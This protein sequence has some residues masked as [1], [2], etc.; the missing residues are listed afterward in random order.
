MGHILYSFQEQLKKRGKPASVPGSHEAPQGRL[1]GGP[2]P[3]KEGEMSAVAWPL[4]PRWS[5]T[6]RI[7]P[8]GGR[9]MH[10]R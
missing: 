5:P 1:S 10:A 9:K 6:L 2:H 7:P 8:F 4:T 3:R